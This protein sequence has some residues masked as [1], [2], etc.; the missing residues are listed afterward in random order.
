MGH[1]HERDA[2]D[3]KELQRQQGKQQ[4]GEPAQ[5]G[6]HISLEAAVGRARVGRHGVGWEGATTQ[7][8]SAR[9]EEQRAQH[10]PGR[11]HRVRSALS[12]QVS[13]F[14]ARKINAHGLFLRKVSGRLLFLGSVVRAR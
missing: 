5:Q 11:L 7:P 9:K 10:A 1:R 13:V 2:R 8:A 14:V 3:E 6:F 4:Q 12:Q